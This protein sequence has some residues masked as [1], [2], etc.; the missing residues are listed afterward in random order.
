MKRRLSICILTAVILTAGAVSA[1][2]LTAQDIV[3][4]AADEYDRVQDYVADAKVSVS[5][6]NVHVPQMD[7]KVY[8][9]K[10]DKLHVESKDGFAALPKQGVMVGNPLREMLKNSELSLAGSEKALGRDCHVIKATYKN[11]GQATRAR[12][13]IDKERWCVV[14]MAVDPESGPS[15]RL[16]MWYARVGGKYWMPSKSQAVVEFPTISGERTQKVSKP[17]KPST[18]AVL[19][20]NY[21]INTGL[22]DKIFKKKT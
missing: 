6:P 16:N 21:K 2:T 3:K 18:V 12:V 19:F 5:S 22:S 1:K 4:R 14:Q 7:I 15:L 8:Y 20:S 13:Y 9:K 11:Q 17:S 10:P